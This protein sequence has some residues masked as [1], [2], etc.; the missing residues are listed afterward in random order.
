MNVIC[1]IF[2]HNYDP[3]PDS[4]ES[5]NAY[6]RHNCLRKNCDEFFGRY[7]LESFEKQSSYYKFHETFWDS[8]T[9]NFIKIVV[10]AFLGVFSVFLILFLI[11]GTV[12]ILFGSIEC[13]EYAKL[14][15]ETRYTFWTNCMANHPKFGWLPIDEYFRTINLNIP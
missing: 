5:S 6:F 12:T 11:I 3:T 4:S 9:W 10:S 2:G 14:G 15:I 1:K 7:K 8:A 13:T